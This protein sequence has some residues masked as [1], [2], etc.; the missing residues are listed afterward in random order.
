ATSFDDA[1]FAAEVDFSGTEFADQAYFMDTRFSN[2]AD[3]SQSNFARSCHF[4][5]SSFARDASFCLAEFDQDAYFSGTEFKRSVSFMG[6]HFKSGWVTPQLHCSGTLDLYHARFDGPVD[7]D[8]EA[9]NVY[10]RGVRWEH[11]VTLRLRG[12][13]ETNLA[14]LVAGRRTATVI[15]LAEMVRNADYPF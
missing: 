15:D 1:I 4:H 7:L 5:R 13:Y 11:S 10:A 8:V 2:E 6:A 9:R 14:R 12:S 3:F